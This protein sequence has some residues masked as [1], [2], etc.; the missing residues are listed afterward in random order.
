MAYS[1]PV[2]LDDWGDRDIALVV[3][4]DRRKYVVVLSNHSVSGIIDLTFVFPSISEQVNVVLFRRLGDS[5]SLGKQFVSL[6][7]ILQR[8][9]AYID[10]LNNSS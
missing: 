9:F 1:G 3:S 7:D 4:R 2:V 6:T 5:S 8:L 10:V